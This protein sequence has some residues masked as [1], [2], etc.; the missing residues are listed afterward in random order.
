M[1]MLRGTD[2]FFHIF[3]LMLCLEGQLPHKI[4]VRFLQTRRCLVVNL[5]LLVCLFILGCGR[6]YARRSFG[7]GMRVPK[8]GMYSKES[9]KATG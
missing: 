3:L 2:F 8:M 7:W 5:G 1:G 9:G 6:M 4:R